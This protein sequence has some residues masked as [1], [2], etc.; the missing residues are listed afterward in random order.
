M[1]IPEIIFLRGL[2]AGWWLDPQCALK[3]CVAA[4][5]FLPSAFRFVNQ[6][7]QLLQILGQST[8]DSPLPPPK[9]NHP[10]W[11]ASSLPPWHLTAANSLINLINVIIAGFGASRHCSVDSAIQ[12]EHFPPHSVCCDFSKAGGGSHCDRVSWPPFSTGSCPW[13][14]AIAFSGD[15]LQVHCLCGK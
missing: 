13:Q 2:A 5:W 7:C 15:F 1:K 10:S 12:A 14:I 4:F 6:I 3:G 8:V 11:L 9:V